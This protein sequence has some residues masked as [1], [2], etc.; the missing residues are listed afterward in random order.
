MANTLS[1][2]AI[3]AR[4]CSQ[5]K[6]RISSDWALWEHYSC[7][8]FSATVESMVPLVLQRLFPLALLVAACGTASNPEDAFDAS[9]VTG[10]NPSNL[11]VS[12]SRDA[13]KLRF[14]IFSSRATR[15]ELNLF[16]E[17]SGKDAALQIPL[18]RTGD[19]WSVDVSRAALNA[20][21]VRGAVYYGYRAWGP[22][23]RYIEAWQPGSD[24]GFVSDVD[25][26][27]NRF[28]PNKLLLDPYAREMSHDPVTASQPDGAAY[29]TGAEHRL[30]DTARIA[31]KGIVVDPAP[32]IS[33]RPTRAFKDETIYEVHVRG[34]TMGDTRLPLT[35]RGTYKAA[36]SRAKALR[37]LGITAVEFLPVQET[38]NDA[39]GSDSTQGSN[40]WG[41]MT[42]A[43]FAPDRRYAADKS[44]GGPTREFRQ[45]VADFHAEGI[46]VYIDAVYNHT[47]EGGVWDQTGD[48]AGLYSF[49]G[50]DNPAYYVLT[51]D[52][53]FNYD[54]TG[55]GGNFNVASKPARDL[56]IDS[57][58]YWHTDLG[59]DGF[60]FD[61][62]SVL[63]NRC[64]QGCFE[65]DKLDPN[66]VLNRATKQLPVRPD[67]G[68]N[69]V[70]LIAEPWAIG[71]GTYQVGNF[72]SG[73]AEWNGTFRDTIR[74][75]QNE[76]GLSAIS[77]GDLAARWAGSSD[78]YQDDGR[79]PWHSVNF[80][81]AHDGFTL[82]DLYSY[83]RKNNL[84]AW[85]FGPSDGGEDTNHSWDQG[86]DA[87]LQRQAARTGMTLLLLSSGVPM[88][89]GGDEYYRT[90]YG[91]NNAYNLDSEKNWLNESD[92]LQNRAFYT[93]SQR[94]LQFRQAHPMFR[95]A[96]FFRGQDN[97]GNGLKD[98]TWYQVSG[99]EANA[100]SMS[101]DEPAFLAMRIDGE[102]ARDTLRSVYVAYNRGERSLD[103]TLPSTGA[104]KRWV[105][106]SD[107][108][109]WMETQANF[110][111]SGQ[112]T[113]L[114]SQYTLNPRSLVLLA[115]Q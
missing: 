29:G 35:E 45:M 10:I 81:V 98:V 39:N 32:R 79:K 40:Y 111:A 49:R 9:D 102:E 41:Y 42:L 50:L 72:P 52:N 84:Q 43:Y 59:V 94:L 115:E 76:R 86:G 1:I 7:S 95:R 25:A 58:A 53:R 13:S 99:A 96:D 4:Q 27:G 48:V 17:A 93:F 103:V 88:I 24:L 87:A 92:R 97:D 23:W 12:A 60:R 37:E 33:G 8:L 73:W 38:Q 83:N 61:L 57:L 67:S 6:T 19:T 78:M 44:P 75:A 85:P 34:L 2:G 82:R 30:K 64:T 100:T 11:G 89:T 55:V 14:R 63:G 54:N 18:K 22:N 106:V 104:G 21:G 68:G 46:K 16:A 110:A 51:Q 70:D 56:V 101:S 114:D 90:Q 105:L 109:A 112:E 3:S 80:V 31:P 62:A 108:A 36:G 107:T 69:G 47:G 74:K 91:N 26:D 15:I 28:N 65:F 5:Q 66:N 113:P 71:S 20:A 77:N